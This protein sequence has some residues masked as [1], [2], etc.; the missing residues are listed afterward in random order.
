MSF[1]T[2]FE[3]GKR[4][5]LSDGRRELIPD[6]YVI[7]IMMQRMVKKLKAIFKGDELLFVMCL[8]YFFQKS[9]QHFQ[10]TIIRSLT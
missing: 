3:N 6:A 4:T 2:S 5:R 1:Q 7:T 8:Y 10:T 9:A